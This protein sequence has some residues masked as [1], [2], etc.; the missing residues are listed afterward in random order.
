ME[1]KMNIFK[2]KKSIVT[3]TGLVLLSGTAL[4]GSGCSNGYYS[5]P[6]AYR[7]AYYYPY[8]YYYYP[9]SSVYFN[10]SSGYYYYPDGVRWIKVRTLPPRFLLDSRNR[11]K[12]VVNS[13]KPYISHNVH[14]QRYTVR[15]TYR[16]NVERN[17]Y[18]RKNNVTRYNNNRKL[19]PRRKLR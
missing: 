2:L 5:A 17:V 10:I 1:I 3:V 9:S 6:P 7:T 15:P 14:K 11:V 4:I 12:V 16:P 19:L 18:E 13:D 8:D